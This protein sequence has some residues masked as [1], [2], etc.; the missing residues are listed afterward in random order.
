MMWDNKFRLSGYFR[1]CLT[2]GEKEANDID[3]VYLRRGAW[4]TGW[5]TK[6]KSS[7]QLYVN[8]TINLNTQTNKNTERKWLFD[9]ISDK[10]VIVEVQIGRGVVKIG[11]KDRDGRDIKSLALAW[12]YDGKVNYPRSENEIA[13]DFLSACV[14]SYLISHIWYFVY[15]F[16]RYIT[17]LSHSNRKQNILTFTF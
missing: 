10:V 3:D 11:H 12:R 1:L 13:G 7:T 14:D 16:T 5:L 2:W 4:L 9:D 17:Y 6:L 15:N 8:F